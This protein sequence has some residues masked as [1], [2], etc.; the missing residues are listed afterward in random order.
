MQRRLLQRRRL[1][2]E[3]R[4][5]G[6]QRRGVLLRKRTPEKTQI[7]PIND[8]ETSHWA[9]SMSYCAIK[10]TDQAKYSRELCGLHRISCFQSAGGRGNFWRLMLTSFLLV[11]NPSPNMH[12]LGLGNC[13]AAK[14]NSKFPDHFSR[15][16]FSDRHP[17]ARH[18]S[19]HRNKIIFSLL[20]WPT[21]AH[22]RT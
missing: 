3:E 2:Q 13:P 19:D 6:M 21:P 10:I 22:H 17:A 15:R 5:Q 18:K 14:T 20:L 4:V 16:P 9:Q 7:T 12:G 11:G 8:F 1:V